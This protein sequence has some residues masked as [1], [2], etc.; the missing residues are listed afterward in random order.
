MA[1][2]YKV[3]DEKIR[4]VLLNSDN[5]EVLIEL[6]NRRGGTHK[7]YKD[8]KDI[9]CILKCLHCREEIIIRERFYTHKNCKCG[10]NIIFFCTPNFLNCKVIYK[11]KK[12]KEWCLRSFNE[13]KD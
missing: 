4:N 7:K 8:I 2:K 13:Y 12:M 9:I 6:A 5:I 11:S 10:K 1:K 3:S